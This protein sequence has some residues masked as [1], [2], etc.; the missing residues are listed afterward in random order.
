MTGIPREVF[1]RSGPAALSTPANPERGFVNWATGRSGLGSDVG[2]AV[3][4]HTALRYTVVYAC[5]SLIASTIASLPLITYRRRANGKGKDRA[6]DA[7]VY[8]LLHDE[9]NPRMTSPVARETGLAHLLTWGNSYAQVVWNKS[10][11]TALEVNPL[12]PDL[13]GVRAQ[14]K[15]L[16]YDVYDRETAKVKVTLDAADV[17]HVPGLGFDGL[18]GYS[19]VWMARAAI[20]SGMTGDQ[21]AERFTSRGFRPPGAI[22][23]RQGVRFK[24]EAD[25]REF[26]SRFQTI[27]SDDGEG[28]FRQVVILEDGATWQDIGVDPESAQ[29]LESRQFDAL[30]ICGIYRVPPHMVGYVEKVTS[31]GTGLEEQVAGF[32][33]FTLLSWITRVEK[34]YNRKLFG[35]GADLHCEHLLAGL[36]R[37]DIVKRTAAM[38]QQLQHGLLNPNEGREL[39]NRNPYPGGDVFFYPLNF[40]RVDED[41]ND[42][43]PPAPE[44]APPAPARGP[45]ESAALAAALRK[46]WAKAVGVCLRREAED[47]RAAARKPAAFLA[48]MDSY[49]ARH[50]DMVA[51][52]VGPIAEAWQAAFGPGP[53]SSYPARHVERSRADL[54]AAAE[55]K[56]DELAA[57][58]D[59]VTGRWQAERVAE[60]VGELEPGGR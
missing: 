56:A 47:A 9:F 41:G 18:I 22:S 55:V 6:T 46:G 7:P 57:A 16:K 30:R 25:A 49:Y 20:R 39:E 5:V 34:E 17:L 37:A 4:E 52:R 42:V 8:H 2:P 29:F 33:K 58:V 53:E 21:E 48:W 24:T 14:G 50:E 54:L 12:S 51:D 35:P 23:F 15:G 26:R 3:N 43:A 11:S 27:H 32:V 59:R 38:V 31:W 1:D 60:A 36:E 45:E 10:R 19:P 13:V 28:G 40:G 44:P